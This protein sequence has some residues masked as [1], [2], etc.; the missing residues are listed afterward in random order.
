MLST[1]PELPYSET[2]ASLNISMMCLKLLRV[3]RTINKN[4]AAHTV[5]TSHKH[6]IMFRSQTADQPQGCVYPD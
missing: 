4:E 6:T 2:E 1:K 5:W 3:R